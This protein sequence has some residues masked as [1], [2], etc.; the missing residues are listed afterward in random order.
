MLY[1]KKPFHSEQEWFVFPIRNA[2]TEPNEC[3]TFDRKELARIKRIAQKN[4]LVRIG[5][6]HSH[7]LTNLTVEE[8]A[9]ASEE[10]LKFAQKFN[11]VI[12]GILVVDSAGVYEH[13]WHDK[14]GNQIDISTSGK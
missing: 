10:D 13:Y 2:H 3:W 12:R 5:N 9:K 8:H 14:F 7:P 6:I 4:G 1:A 11:D